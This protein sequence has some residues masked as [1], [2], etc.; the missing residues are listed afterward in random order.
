MPVLYAG[1]DVDHRRDAAPGAFAPLLV[2]AP[3]GHTEEDLSTAPDRRV[4]VPAVAAAGLKGHIVH[5]HLTGGEGVQVALAYKNTGQSCRWGRMGKHHLPLML[6]LCRPG[7]HP[8][9]QTSLAMRKA[10]QALGQL[11]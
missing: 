3:S 4:D 1:W 8:S 5:P 9:A 2:P 6:R 7:A 11:A 10:A